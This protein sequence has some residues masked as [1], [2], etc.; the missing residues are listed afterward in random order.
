MDKMVLIFMIL[1][2][3]GGIA[4]LVIVD[5]TAYFRVIGYSFMTLIGCARTLAMMISEETNG[6]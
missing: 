2:G 5:E 4:G 1:L 6:S 3:A